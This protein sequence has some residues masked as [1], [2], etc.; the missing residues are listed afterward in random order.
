MKKI[1]IMGWLVM[2]AAFITT[3]TACSSDENNEVIGGTPVEP[4]RT[5]SVTVGA[6]IID[7][8]IT[9]SGIKEGT[10]TLEFTAD[11]KL[12]VRAMYG[13]VEKDNDNNEYYQFMLRGYLTLVEL[14]DDGSA[15]FSGTLEQY[16]RG[17]SDETGVYTYTGPNSISVSFT[18][19]IGDATGGAFAT[20][21]HKDATKTEGEIEGDYTDYVWDIYYE[22]YVLANGNDCVNTLMTK[23]LVVTG[24][25]N[26]EEKSFKLNG[27]TFDPILNCTINELTVGATYRVTYTYGNDE[28][29]LSNSVEA[30]DVGTARF[31]FFGTVGGKK[32]HV[33][34]L[35]NIKD[36]SDTKTFDLGE[37]DLLT[38][39]IYNVTRPKTTN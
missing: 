36:A 26:A 24:A 5:V 17:E 14:A 30:D 8:A 4:V 21:V 32:S 27:G 18:D 20:L 29:P 31:A 34:T 16:N 15:S 37:K 25:Y 35:V 10:H 7:D 13:N 1:Q 22:P 12:F 6:G 33:I 2:A 38:K 28:E 39:K 11:D 23:N 19:P 9:R 3:F